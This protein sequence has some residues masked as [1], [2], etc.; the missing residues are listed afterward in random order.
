M[1]KERG[2]FIWWALC[3][4]ALGLVGVLGACGSTAKTL[5]G[6]EKDAVLTYSEPMT[7]NLL[8]G[9]SSNEYATFSRDL[10]DAMK[11]A[12]PEAQLGALRAQLGAAIGSYV[13]REVSG[14]VQDGENIAVIYK[15]KFEKDDPVTM[16]VV[17]ETAPPH[18]ISGL[19][20]DS[21]KLRK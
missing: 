6:A 18:R 8:A 19:W 3:V 5:E 14:V 15:A 1:S 16:R 17:F 20:F 9:I 10:D 12:M 13:S 21:A 2:T 7:D 4:L 11:K